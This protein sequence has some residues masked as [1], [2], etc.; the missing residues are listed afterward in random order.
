VIV[1]ILL[2]SASNDAQAPRP[3]APTL[4]PAVRFEG[5]VVEDETG[6][7]L[8]NARVGQMFGTVDAPPVAAL[9]DGEGRFAFTLPG[10]LS[11]IS[12]IKSGYARGEVETSPDGRPVEIRLKRGA[13]IGGRVLDQFGEPVADAR[14]MLETSSNGSSDRRTVAST[15]T[16]DLGEYRLGGLPE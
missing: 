1:G 11:R 8:P 6:L 14:V 10:G 7:G 3:P 15:T 12:A 9:T 16:D 4:R 2:L 5:R 13:V